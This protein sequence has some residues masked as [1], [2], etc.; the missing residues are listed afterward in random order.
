MKHIQS[1]NTKKTERKGNDVA[2]IRPS[3]AM[4]H[5]CV[6]IQCR[7]YCDPPSSA[8]FGLLEKILNSLKHLSVVYLLLL[9]FE[10]HLP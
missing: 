10:V 9:Q 3:A 4:R 6:L 1:K 7:T 5:D 8:S 2:V